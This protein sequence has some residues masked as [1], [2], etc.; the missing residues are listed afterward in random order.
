MTTTT[1]A[2]RSNVDWHER[3]PRE[4][5]RTLTWSFALHVAAVVLLFVLP[6]AWFSNTKTTDS[7]MTIS[8]QGMTGT[9]KTSGMTPISSR[10]IEQAVPEP[11]RPTPARPVAPLKPDPDAA[12]IAKTPPPP[13]TKLVETSKPAPPETRPP[14]TG[15]Q[16]REGTARVETNSTSL[17]Q[18]I[19]LP[20]GQ[21]TGGE[22]DLT[23]FCCM[24]YI[25][26]MSD[27]IQTQW[28]KDPN[29]R[30]RTVMRF[31]VKRDGTIVDI[32]PVESSGSGLLDRAAERALRTA[33]FPPLPAL[34]T[35]Q[36]LIIRL[37]FD[38]AIK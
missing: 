22:T 33:K 4:L 35:N 15:A 21:G 29:G 37:G 24:Q 5:N 19:T 25:S 28:Q 30:G 23:N 27:I 16:T 38:H 17:S 6:R 34:Y 20:G 14:T 12:A 2:T 7:V 8:L 1:V 11:K 10:P 31:T 9:Q 36:T 3:N 13:T 18:G 26:T 32:T